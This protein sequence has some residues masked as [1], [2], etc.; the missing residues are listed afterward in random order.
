MA[1]VAQV[2]AQ[3]GV[4]R[5]GESEVD[6]EVGRRSGIG[7]H[8]GMHGAEQL[9]RALVARSSR[10]RSWPVLGRSGRRDILGVLFWNTVPQASS[11]ALEV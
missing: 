1:A 4:P 7:L 6:S 5:F 8:V 10:R 11:T 9:L 3:D 2:E